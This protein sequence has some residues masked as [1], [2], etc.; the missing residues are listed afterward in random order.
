[1]NTIIVRKKADLQ[2]IQTIGPARIALLGVSGAGKTTLGVRLAKTLNIGYVELDSL[3]LNENWRESDK[4]EFRKKV[5]EQLRDKKYY[6][7]DGNY[8]SISDLTW[9]TCTVF[10]CLD[11]Q[12]IVIMKRVILRTI[13][14]VITQEEL[15]NGNRETFKKSFMSRKSI[16]LWSWN[17]YQKRKNDYRDLQEK[18]KENE[19]KVIIILKKPKAAK[20]LINRIKG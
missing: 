3:F 20:W 1:M 7:I 11:Y 4:E 8:R 17:T 18:Y 19:D 14:R 6:I 9:D 16:I 15:W 10:I 12:K 2:Y 5:G 13:G